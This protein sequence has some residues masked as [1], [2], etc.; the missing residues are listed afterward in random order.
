MTNLFY[1][2]LSVSAWVGCW[3]VKPSKCLMDFLKVRHTGHW[4]KA[5]E[6]MKHSKLM[7]YVQES[8]SQSR[9]AV[10]FGES[11]F[12]RKVSLPVLVPLKLWLT[13]KL[14]TML[15]SS[16]SELTEEK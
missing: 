12:L 14:V 11:Y 10:S 13:Y 15:D 9:L 5:Q 6:R 3:A 1:L 4:Q 8:K 16:S 7:K 2:L